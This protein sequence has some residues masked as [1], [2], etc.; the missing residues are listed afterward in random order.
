VVEEI[1]STGI[2]GGASLSL[3]FSGEGRI[4]GTA[5]C[6]SG[7]GKHVLSSEDQGSIRARRI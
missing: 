1:D 5:S 6:N 4:S 7:I 3:N 2:I